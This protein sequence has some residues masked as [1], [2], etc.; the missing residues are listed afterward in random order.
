MLHQP[1][2]APSDP[3]QTEAETATDVFLPRYLARIGYR[4]ALAPMSTP[5]PVSASIASNGI[6]PLGPFAENA[7]IRWLLRGVAYPAR[8]EGVPYPSARRP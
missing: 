3:A 5:A 2:A 8:R 6:C 4:G 7:S 1:A